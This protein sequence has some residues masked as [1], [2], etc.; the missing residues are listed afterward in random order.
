[1]SMAQAIKF[2]VTHGLVAPEEPKTKEELEEERR[3]YQARKA[4]MEEEDRRV[5]EKYS[6]LCSQYSQM[7]DAAA[8]D[9]FVDVVYA[10]QEMSSYYES[11]S[12]LEKY[13]VN[14][15]D[16]GIHLR[17]LIQTHRVYLWKQLRLKENYKIREIV[18]R[19]ITLCPYFDLRTIQW[20][21]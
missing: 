19:R 15:E 3:K 2:A 10:C 21:L 8:Y 7:S 18:S 16:P 4:A 5:N 6:Y 20:V 14:Y 12:Y 9:V 17:A 11:H 1:M 13:H